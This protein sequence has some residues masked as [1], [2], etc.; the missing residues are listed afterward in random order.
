MQ[1]VTSD[2]GKFKV[3]SELPHVARSAVEE[4]VISIRQFI[5]TENLGVGDG[6]PSERELCER[7]ETS[8]NTVREAMR[9][10]KA[11]GLVEVRPKVGATI[12]D[13]R[14]ARAFDLFS[15]NVMDVSRKMFSDVQGMRSLLE[16]ASV[17][18]L[19]DRVSN[20]DLI[21]LQHINS[22]LQSVQ[23]IEAGGEIDFRFHV[24]LLSI[25]ENRAIL[26]VFQII[27]PVVIRIMQNGKTLADFNVRVFGEHMDILEALEARDRISYQ[28]SAQRHL[29]SGMAIF[30]EEHEM[31][32]A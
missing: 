11:Y 30:D 6:L 10:L 3:T 32:E 8:R 9:M 5:H 7:F 19:L 22:E 2:G 21:E 23:S 26:D 15:L 18:T 1:G 25:L 14:M 12:I 24:R 20:I 29:K 13:N 31:N 16:V 28:Y 4:L 17:D 27:K